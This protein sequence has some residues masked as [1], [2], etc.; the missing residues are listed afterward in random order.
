ML[1]NG[2]AKRGGVLHGIGS[3]PAVRACLS[4]AVWHRCCVALYCK[5]SQWNN[6]CLI[7]VSKSEKPGTTYELLRVAR[8]QL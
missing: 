8:C 6:G 1:G 2:I 7:P 3:A 4:P 5:G